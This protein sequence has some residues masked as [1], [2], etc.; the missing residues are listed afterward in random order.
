MANNKAK[1]ELWVKRMCEEFYKR[2]KKHPKTIGRVIVN[3]T[4]SVMHLDT[5][6]PLIG[7]AKCNKTDTFNEEIGTAIAYARMEGYVVPDYVTNDNKMVKI[8]SLNEDDIFIYDDE[9]YVYTGH[10]TNGRAIC[11][12]TESF[13]TCYFDTDDKV[14]R[15][16]D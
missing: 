3:R 12:N 6:Y 14:E 7:V 16:D 9:K 13:I 10:E 15:V 5:E 2:E 4:V 8:D 11:V 1:A